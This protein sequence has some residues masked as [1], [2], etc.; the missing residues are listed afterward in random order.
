[1]GNS[2][3]TKIFG[4]NFYTG[5]RIIDIS[6]TPFNKICRIMGNVIKLKKPK[7]IRSFSW[8]RCLVLSRLLVETIKK[9]KTGC[10]NIEIV[11]IKNFFFIV[12][13]FRCFTD[14]FTF[15]FLETRETAKNNLVF[16][17][18]ISENHEFLINFFEFLKIRKLFNIH[19]FFIVKLNSIFFL[20]LF[21]TCLFEN[22]GRK[23]FTF[24]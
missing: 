6:D 23:I 1:M 5:N 21:K 3:E 7:V 13:T 4:V 8:G 20:Q 17:Y 19:V 18:D 2:N 12:F 15:H 16:F 9:S 10:K 11:K 14:Y 24:N 22:R